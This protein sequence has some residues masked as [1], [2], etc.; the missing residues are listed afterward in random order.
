MRYGLAVF[1]D[2]LP[3]LHDVHLITAA[4]VRVLGPAGQPVQGDGD[5]VSA[6]PTEVSVLPG[7][8]R[9]LVPRRT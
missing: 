8:L 9:V 7:A 2:R 1:L 5:I 4:N 6:L 3:K